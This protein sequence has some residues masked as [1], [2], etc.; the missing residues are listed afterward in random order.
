LA[1]DAIARTRGGERKPTPFEH[2]LQSA[3]FGGATRGLATGDGA[4]PV[5]QTRSWV[6]KP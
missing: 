1:R 3:A 4:Q 2:L 6:V 5:V